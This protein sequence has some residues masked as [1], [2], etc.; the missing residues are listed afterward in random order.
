MVTAGVQFSSRQDTHSSPAL[1]GAPS[2]AGLSDCTVAAE[3]AAAR[4][5]SS[6]IPVGD[7][8]AAEEES[9]A[10]E[11]IEFVGV[12]EGAREALR[13]IF[14][15]EALGAENPVLD[16]DPALLDGLPRVE[17]VHDQPANDLGDGGTDPVRPP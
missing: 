17:T 1:Q 8:Y 16:M 10:V 9:R 13:A 2:S 3:I 14:D 5:L 15:G 6:G 4:Q 12:L 11:L 7:M